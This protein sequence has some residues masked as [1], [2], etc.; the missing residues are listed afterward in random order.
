M[1]MKYSQVIGIFAVLA[2]IGICYL[3]WVYIASIDSIVTGFQS[4]GTAF[5]EPGLMNVILSVVCLVFFLVRKIWAKRINV[6][7]GA[8]DF[9]WSVR[10]YLLLTVCQA[11]ECPE[12]RIGLYLQL[13]ATFIILLMT[14][15]PKIELPRDS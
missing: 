13:V 9:A 3:P 12:K 10:N 7:I 6:F 1:F 5:G 2:M 15:L 4:R 11:G 14:F 8:I